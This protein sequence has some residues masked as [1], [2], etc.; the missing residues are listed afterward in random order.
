MV[1]TKP[2]RTRTSL[3]GGSDACVVGSRR[4]RVARCAGATM[5]ERERM[6]RGAKWRTSESGGIRFNP[7]FFA[8]WCW[9]YCEV[10]PNDKPEGVSTAQ[11]RFDETSR[12]CPD[13]GSSRVS[14][15]C[16]YNRATDGSRSRAAPK[17]CRSARGASSPAL[18]MGSD[19]GNPSAN[20]SSKQTQKRYEVSM[21]AL[22]KRGEQWLPNGQ[23]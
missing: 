13:R 7:R 1:G 10:E 16:D 19:R 18:T 11:R 22:R 4:L 9:S 8:N 21:N 23:Q 6:P 2:F 14:G 20:G 12:V 15:W 17:K 3:Q 5:T